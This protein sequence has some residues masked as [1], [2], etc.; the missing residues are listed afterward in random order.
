MSVTHCHLCGGLIPKGVKVE[1]EAPRATAQHAEPHDGVCDCTP[2]V[3]Y[4]EAPI[5]HT[6]DDTTAGQ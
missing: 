5:E 2:P 4:Q 3:V 6:E 1:Y